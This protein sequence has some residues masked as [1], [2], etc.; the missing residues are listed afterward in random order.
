MKKSVLS[1]VAALAAAAVTVSAQE[2]PQRSVITAANMVDVVTGKVTEY[3]AIFVENGRITSIADARTVRW[4]S[5]V[6]HIDLSG[7]TLLPG[8]ID[9][10]VHLDSSPTY[11]GYNSLQ[12]T[13]RFWSFVAAANARAM[14][15]A[16][17]TKIS[18]SRK[19]PFWVAVGIKS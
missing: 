19:T 14:L 16:G 15:E 4:G 3:P 12:F 10:H 18:F 17:F 8:L 1:I 7:K 11:G 13:D 9:M 6:E 2:A 5:D